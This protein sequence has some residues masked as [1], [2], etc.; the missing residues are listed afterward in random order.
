M[1]LCTL[2]G[3]GVGAGGWG[4]LQEAMDQKYSC[5]QLTDPYLSALMHRLI[6]VLM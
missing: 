1:H 5:G 6:S 2:S 3:V 4:A